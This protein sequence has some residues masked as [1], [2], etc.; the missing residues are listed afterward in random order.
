MAK[1]DVYHFL[2]ANLDDDDSETL[3]GEVIPCLATTVH[4]ATPLSFVLGLC[5]LQQKKSLRNIQ[6]Y[7]VF[8]PN[9][10]RQYSYP[11]PLF[12]PSPPLGTSS[13]ESRTHI[14][15]RWP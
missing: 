6:T 4:S 11:A 15:S 3:V 8:R 12:F 9:Y 7:E 1:K 5:G 14:T 10:Q 13:T 2:S